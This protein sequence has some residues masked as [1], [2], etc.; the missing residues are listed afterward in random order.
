LSESNS[1]KK[2]RILSKTNNADLYSSYSKFNSKFQ[3]FAKLASYDN[4]I[5]ESASL[6]TRRQTSFLNSLN[7]SHNSAL[8]LDSISLKK[9]I[10]YNFKSSISSQKDNVTSFFNLKNNKNLFSSYDSLIFKNSSIFL[11]NNS[12]LLHNTKTF[13]D[14]FSKINNDSDKKKLNY[15]FFKLLNSTFAKKSITQLN[16]Y[17]FINKLNFEEDFF[18]QIQIKILF[19]I[20]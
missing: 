6:G 17:D 11:N 19:L 2:I 4:S 5:Y 13:F 14:L 12:I 8:S 20:F 10:K 7:L 16:T 9:I 15:S 3:T 18:F 1:F